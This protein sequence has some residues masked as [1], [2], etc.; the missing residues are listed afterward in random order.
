MTSLAE[1]IG[2]QLAAL[3]ARTALYAKHLASQHALAIRADESVNP[4]STIK[5]PI[6][7]LAYRDADAGLFDLDARFTLG[8]Q[9]L[10]RGSGLLQ[11]FAPGLQPTYRDLVTQMIVTSDNTATDILI[12]R[13]GLARVNQMLADLGYTETRLQT[14]TGDLFRQLWAL[15]DP[16]NAA[17]SSEE[18]YALGF[19]V[20]ADALSRAFGF[21]SDPEEWLGRTT[22]REMGRLLE[23]LVEGQ[24]ASPTSS[25][26]MQRTLQQQF[27]NTRLPQRID[28]RVVIGHKT[29][30]WGSIAGN[31]VG[32][33]YSRS[34]P[35]VI[36]LFITHSRGPFAELEA[37]H[38]AIA[39]TILDHWEHP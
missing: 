9:D 20:D 21:L 26:E 14:T 18:V 31:D 3:D 22:A 1:R 23:Q 30:D 19:P 35:I 36:A 37:T 25:A 17:L 11:T 33:L 6:M 27:Y 8:P 5:I 15:A 2:R 10:R 16:A 38:G 34:G 4:L 39:E 13:L 12:A 32:I 24:L 28:D 7:V 29:G